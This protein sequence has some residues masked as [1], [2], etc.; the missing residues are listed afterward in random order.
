MRK[1]FL[2]ILLALSLAVGCKAQVPAASSADAALNHRIEVLVRSHIGLPADVDVLV[3]ARKPSSFPGYDSLEITLSRGSQKQTMEFLLTKDNKTLARLDTYSLEND[4]LLKID[5][6]GRPVRGNPEAKVTVVN[7]DDLECPYCSRMHAELFP[8]TL[9]R[10]KNLVRF[11]YM[12]F[13]LTEIHPW[14]MHA[15]ID[16]NCLGSLNQQSYWDFVDYIHAHGSEVEGEKR[17]VAKSL[18]ALDRIARQK[19]TEAHLDASALGTCLA[20]QDETKVHA[21]M[22]QA[23]ELGVEGTPALFV[24]GEHINGAVPANQIWKVIDRALKA[25]GIQPPAEPATQ[26]PASGDASR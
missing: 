23:L 1:P 7:F 3:G 2:A 11:V 4:P 18:A 20:A 14:A 10:Y 13:P 24:D 6:Q 16:A 25:N 9:D 8:E 19:G 15:A 22:K 17:E 21:S 5:T 12:D 26:E